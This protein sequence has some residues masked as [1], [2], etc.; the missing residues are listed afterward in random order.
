MQP[1]P[2]APDSDLPSVLKG[3]LRAAALHPLRHRGAGPWT[4]PSFIDRFGAFLDAV[5]PAEAA[6]RRRRQAKSARRTRSGCDDPAR[7]RRHPGQHPPAYGRFGFPHD[8]ASFLQHRRSGRRPPLRAGLRP[9]VTTAEPWDREPDGRRQRPSSQAADHAQHRL[10]LS[11][12]AGARPADAHAALLPDEFIDGMGCR[13]H[14]L[15]DVGDSAPEHWD[16]VWRYAPERALAGRSI[17]GSRST[18]APT[19]TARR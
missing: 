7:P 3:A 19:R 14:I 12:P 13:A 16:P 5:R 17:S 1:F 15:G 4:T 10:Q 6:R 9:R 2:T 18:S 8:R 11:R